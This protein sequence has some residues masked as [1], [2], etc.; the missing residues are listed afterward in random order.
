MSNIIDQYIS[1]NDL[2]AALEECMRSNQYNLGLLLAKIWSRSCQSSKFYEL[3]AQLIGSADKF[4]RDEEE[5]V[6]IEDEGADENPPILYNESK[7]GVIADNKENE[8]YLVSDREN[9]ASDDK[10]P[11]LIRVMLLCWWMDS[12]SLCE[13]WN[14]M[15]KGN[16]TWNTIQAVWEEPVD[17][18]AVITCPPIHVFPDPKRT[19]I[20][21]MEPNMDKHPEMWGSWAN[22]PKDQF[23]FIGYHDE[24][25]NNNE[26]H[27]ALTYNQLMTEEIKK[28]EAVSNILSAVLSH[29]YSDPGHIKRIDFVKF[30]ERKDFPV[31]VYGDNKFLWKDYKG[32][33]PLRQKDEALLPYKYTINVENFPVKGYYSEKLIDGILAECLTFYNGCPNIRD[34]V[35]ERAFVWLDL[36]NFE[37]DYKKIK[38]AIEEDWWGQRLPYIQ[39]EKRRIINDRQFFPR[40]ERIIH[41]HIQEQNKEN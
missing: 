17:Y 2:D 29:K 10:N 4:K 16:C 26:W 19:I 3:Y 20:F 41:K 12:K 32:S 39:N 37:E 36:S 9:G 6:V 23:I 31:H 27:L 21:R 7:D 35:D 38:R 14:K 34:Y 25:Y 5:V 11:T 15:S 40:L 8:T 13:D 33:P 24:H 28:D 22:P 1:K 30:L 18:Y